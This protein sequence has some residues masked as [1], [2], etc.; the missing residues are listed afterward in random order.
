MSHFFIK[1]PMLLSP[2]DSSGFGTIV[3]D[4]RQKISVDSELQKIWSSQSPEENLPL[5]SCVPVGYLRL[6]GVRG[7]L[8]S[9]LQEGR[10]LDPLSPRVQ[11]MLIDCL[12]DLYEKGMLEGLAKLFPEQ[13][14]GVLP[15]SLYGHISCNANPQSYHQWFARRQKE[16]LMENMSDVSIIPSTKLKM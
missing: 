10:F 9:P 11:E 3:E 13:H 15:L 6:I 8:Y 12:Q 2:D 4:L 5:I 1:L 14:H 16:H 7:L